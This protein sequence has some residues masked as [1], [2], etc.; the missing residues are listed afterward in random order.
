[1]LWTGSVTLQK[2]TGLPALLSVVM[3][4][5]VVLNPFKVNSCKIHYIVPTKNKTKHVLPNKQFQ[6]SSK[7]ILEYFVYL[8]QFFVVV[9]FMSYFVIFWLTPPTPYLDDVIYE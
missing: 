2:K 7:V 9:T 8:V 6:F 1:M 5:T 4:Y 3:D